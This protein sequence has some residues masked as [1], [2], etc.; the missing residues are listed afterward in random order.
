MESDACLVHT[1]TAMFVYKHVCMHAYIYTYITHTFQ[2]RNIHN[3][4]VKSFHNF[5]ICIFP[6]FP[7]FWKYRNLTILEI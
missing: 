7:Y 1:D 2:L 4:R 3:F 6:E 5:Q